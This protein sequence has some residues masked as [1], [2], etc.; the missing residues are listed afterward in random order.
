[1]DC[2]NYQLNFSKVFIYGCASKVFPSPHVYWFLISGPFSG[3][4]VPLW[5][6]LVKGIYFWFRQ[7][8]TCDIQ[9][10]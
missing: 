4:V 1:M 9:S 5:T 6:G 7:S 3:T 2:F 10:S 8:S